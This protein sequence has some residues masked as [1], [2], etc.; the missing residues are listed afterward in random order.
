MCV[1]C[2]KKQLFL[3]ALQPW[4]LRNLVIR[5]GFLNH[6]VIIV[7]FDSI[8][9]KLILV[10]DRECDQGEGK[11][12]P[13]YLAVLS[14]QAESLRPLLREGYSPDAQSCREFGCCCPLD[15]A[16]LCNSWKYECIKTLFYIFIQ[17]LY[18][19]YIYF[20]YSVHSTSPYPLRAGSGF[21]QSR[22]ITKMLLADGAHVS[23][24]T[25]IM[26]LQG[27]IPEHLSLILEYSG[28]PTGERLEALVQAALS[29]VAHASFW[30]PHLLKAG[31]DPLLLLQQKM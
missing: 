27:D 6:I 25:Y 4:R 22:E 30:L 23:L 21:Q 31:L 20:L 15:A 9:E 7:T 12:S 17:Y 28:L 10:T 18:W 5:F 1:T 3:W 19:Y 13:V 16:L 14:G 11:V 29:K 2:R 26:T 24:A 8:L